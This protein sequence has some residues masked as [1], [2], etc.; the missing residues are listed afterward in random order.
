MTIMSCDKSKLDVYIYNC[1]TGE[2]KGFGNVIFWFLQILLVYCGTEY[3][4]ASRLRMWHSNSSLTPSRGSNYK[5]ESNF[6]QIL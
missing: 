2:I 6:S 1:D 4:L 5:I 3:D